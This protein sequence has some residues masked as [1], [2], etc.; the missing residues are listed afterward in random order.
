MYLNSTIVHSCL[1]DIILEHQL[2][3][4]VSVVRE[5]GLR[6]GRRP[7]RLGPKVTRGAIG[8]YT[9]QVQILILTIL[10]VLILQPN[11]IHILNIGVASCLFG[12]SPLILNVKKNLCLYTLFQG[13]LHVL[14]RSK[15][16]QTCILHLNLMPLLPLPQMKRGLAMLIKHLK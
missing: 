11:T 14:Q 9:W 7:G 6:H 1:M 5:L 2:L 3:G 15:P 13:N 16:K 10:I 4:R 12:D 8:N